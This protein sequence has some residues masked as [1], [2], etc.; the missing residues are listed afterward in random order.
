MFFDFFRDLIEKRDLLIALTLKELKT[1]YKSATLGFLWAFLN[2]LFLMIVLS[3]VFTIIVRIQVEKYPLFLFV[4]L[5]PWTFFLQ[6]LTAG[7]SSLTNNRDLLK[8]AAFPRAIL[9]LS[10]I[11]SNLI[12]FLISL[13]ILLPIL[14]IFNSFSFSIFLL[15]FIIALHLAFT[16]GLVLITSSLDIYYRDVSFVIQALMLAWF[17]LT[18][19]LYPISMIPEK[20]MYLYALNPVVGITSLYHFALLGRGIENFFVL[21]P[22]ILFTLFVFVFGIILFKKREPLF[23]DW[24]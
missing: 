14:F 1:R 19:I 23:A 9:P 15:P 13:L 5:L 3:L 7:T 22:S 20:F 4:G 21:V 8:K 6:S 10:S 17:Y 12:N 18:P 16:I 2:P 24:A 11:F